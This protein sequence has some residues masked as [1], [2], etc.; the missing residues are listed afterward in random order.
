MKFRLNVLVRR[1]FHNHRIFK[2]GLG[3]PGQAG[4][5]WLGVNLLAQSITQKQ[6]DMAEKTAERT[7]RD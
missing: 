6:K 7:I 4:E 5:R 3:L 1:S 2:A